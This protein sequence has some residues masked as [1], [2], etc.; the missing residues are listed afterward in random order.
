MTLTSEPKL[1]PW[2]GHC[3][4]DVEQK[5]MEPQITSHTDSNIDFTQLRRQHLIE[6]DEL[7]AMIA[8]TPGKETSSTLRIVDMRGFVRTQTE[9][10]GKQ[11]ADYLG[12]PE[13]YAVGHLPGAIYL[14]WT[15]DI[16]DL[17]DPV[18]AQLASAARMAQ[19]L[20]QAGIG[21][22]SEV[23]VYDAHPASQF[24][25]RLWWALRFYGHTNVRVLNGG[26]A[27][28]TAEGRPVTAEVSHFP[29]A[30]FTPH[31]EPEWRATAEEVRSLLGDPGV[32]LLDARDE[33]QYTG[34][35]VRGSRGGHIPGAHNVPREALIAPDGTFRTPAELQEIVAT[36]GAR[37]EARNVAYCNGGV[38]A[39]SVL[40]ALSMLGYPKLTNYD[41]SWNE[42]AER[43]DLPINHSSRQ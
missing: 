30:T 13:V 33:G 20:G 26:W 32:A 17:D 43:E 18:P 12:A 35:I 8:T 10:D 2:E 24:A 5:S 4:L 1:E 37:R 21:D 39:T 36:S 16:V 29:P 25:T 6:T 22:N 3:G 19:V 42:W 27:K 34:R 38:A 41:G 28:W 15:R 9:P 40:F 7:A 11:T 23:V 14:D 31:P